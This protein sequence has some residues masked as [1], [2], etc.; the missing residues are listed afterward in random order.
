M[1]S[2]R[3]GTP[4][5][6]LHTGGLADTVVDTSAVNLEQGIAD[7][8]V[9]HEPLTSALKGTILRAIDYFYQPTVWQHIQTT[10]MKHAFGWDNS[11]AAYL[12]LYKKGASQ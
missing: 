11:A 7:G 9:F 8:F 1:Y 2:L 6:V 12:A 3:Y 5:L 4:P 10:G